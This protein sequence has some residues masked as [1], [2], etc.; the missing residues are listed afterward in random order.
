MIRCV[1]CGRRIAPRWLILG[2]PWSS[3]TCPDC[4]SVLGGTVL[5]FALTSVAVGALGIVVIGV[6]KGRM[7]PATLIPPL[8]FAL[9]VF[10]LPLPRQIKRLA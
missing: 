7:A 6:I 3:Y 9:A 5:R 4:G 2:L 8:A 10:L 1:T